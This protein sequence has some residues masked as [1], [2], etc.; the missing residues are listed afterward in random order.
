MSEE[1]RRQRD[2]CSEAD[3]PIRQMLLVED[4]LVDI[5]VT[6]EV[7]RESRTPIRL[8]VVRDGCEAMEFLRREGKYTTAPRP[9]LILLD[10]NLPK[11]DGRELLAEI[12]KDSHLRSI[13][14]I[15]V[16]TSLSGNDVVN[17][18]NLHANCLIAKPLELDQYTAM[19]RSIEDFWFCVVRLPSD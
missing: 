4:N 16:A 1:P 7:L 17:S 9:H 13:P 15:V 6:Q 19:L 2:D 12:K 8:N 10:L 14:V 3:R 5:M 18:Y 11:K